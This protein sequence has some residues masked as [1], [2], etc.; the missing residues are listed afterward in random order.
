[1][2]S[3]NRFQN[4]KL[5]EDA[6][7]IFDSRTYSIETKNFENMQDIKN[8]NLIIFDNN[9]SFENSD[10]KDNKFNKVF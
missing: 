9:L 3:D 6:Q 2:F 5:N 7:T 4:I 10:F 1:M 8:K